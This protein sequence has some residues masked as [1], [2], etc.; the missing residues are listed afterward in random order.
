MGNFGYRPEDVVVLP[1]SGV[2]VANDTL[3]IYASQSDAAA[4]TNLITTVTVTNGRWTWT[5]ADYTQAWA[6]SS[7]GLIWLIEDDTTIQSAVNTAIAAKPLA[8]GETTDQWVF[9]A[10]YAG[11]REVGFGMRGDYSFFPK[12]KVESDLSALTGKAVTSQASDVPGWAYTVLYAG[13]REPAFGMRDD[14]S[15]YPKAKVESEFS[16]SREVF[17]SSV[18]GWRWYVMYSGN[19][20]VAMGQRANGL[21]YPDTLNGGGSSGGGSSTNTVLWGDSLTERWASLNMLTLPG[22]TVIG[23]GIGGQ[24]SYQIAARQGGAPARVTTDIIIPTS[25][26]V[27]FTLDRRLRSDTTTTTKVV[28]AGVAGVFISTGPVTANPDAWCQ[29]TFTPTTY[30]ASPVPALAGT[31]VQS[32]FDYRSAWPILRYGRNNFKQS[33][34][35]QPNGGTDTPDQ[36]VADLQA[37]LVWMTD[38]ARAHALILSIP[39]WVGEPYGSSLRAKLD[40][41]N[42]AIRDAFPTMW[43]DDSAILRNTDVMAAYG[44][45][46][47]SQD[48]TDISNGYTPTSLRSDDGHFNASGYTI[49]NA[50]INAQYVVRGWVTP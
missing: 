46:P 49:I 11:N 31:P 47:T 6:R 33:G 36:I 30:P 4:S 41:A 22:R 15:F 10:T 7:N 16:A 28:I 45:T 37:S 32:G 14:G 43:F 48:S 20:E 50:L 8:R 27:S 13:N 38:D 34:T 24:T 2:P 1:N 12:A 5:N 26:S 9:S 19:R 18:Q 44:F 3:G 23:Q 25:G 21:F 17:E 39:P 42:N 29:G 35:T 40:A